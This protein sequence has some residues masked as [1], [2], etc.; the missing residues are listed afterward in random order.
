MREIA[1]ALAGVIDRT[2]PTL[3]QISDGDASAAVLSGG[4]SRKQLIGH[5]IDSAANNHQRF[6]RAALAGSLVWPGYDQD[7]CVKLQAFQE[8]PWP[9]LLD[10]WESMNRLLVHV[11]ANL[12]P[13]AATAPCQIEDHAP[14]PLA[15][16][17][18][19]YVTH[20]RHHLDQLS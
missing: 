11:L 8:A 5:L 12:P 3:R 2:A 20:L 10:V 1:A 19:Q 16:L 7:G 4:W 18:Q 17:A 6:V 14:I 9:M 15:E 13:A